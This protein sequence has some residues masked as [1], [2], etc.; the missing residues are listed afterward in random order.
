M[1]A[2]RLRPM[3]GDEYDAWLVRSRAGYAQDMI[4]NAGFGEGEA[5]AKAD[6]DYEFFLPD[7]RETQGAFLLTVE[8]AGSG[9]TVGWIWLVRRPRFGGGE[10]EA[11]FLFEITIGEERRGRGYGRAAMLALEEHV[12]ELGLDTIDLNVFGG[13]EI[14]RGL[15]RSL[16]YAETSVIMTKRLAEVRPP[17]GS[18]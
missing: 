14:A 5:W 2:V 18:H 11:A 3:S 8:D 9:E 4:A 15:Y 6:R 13:N 10:T 17:G 12:R 7:G 1:A 16:G